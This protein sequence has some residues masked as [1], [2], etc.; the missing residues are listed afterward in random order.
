MGKH[1]N[2]RARIPAPTR[3][4]AKVNK[5]S[6][7]F[8]IGNRTECWLWTGGLNKHGYGVFR[9]EQSHN[10]GSHVWAYGPVPDGLEL[11]HLCRVRACV[12]PS[13]L[14]AVSHAINNRRG[15]SKRREQT[16]CKRGHEFTEENTYRRPDRNYARRCQA[17]RKHTAELT[18]DRRM[19]LQRIRRAR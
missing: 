15:R 10:V 14:E 17:C 4:W 2:P 5:N 11:A 7:V 19:E 13:H 9:D 12:R 3:F 8:Y 6:G 18:H 16:F 1:Q